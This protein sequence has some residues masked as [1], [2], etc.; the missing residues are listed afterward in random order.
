[1]V[2][3]KNCQRDLGGDAFNDLHAR[4]GYLGF[5]GEGDYRG[6]LSASS[7]ICHDTNFHSFSWPPKLEAIFNDFLH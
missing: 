2:K 4:S 6:G 5:Q 3:R 7:V 1:M